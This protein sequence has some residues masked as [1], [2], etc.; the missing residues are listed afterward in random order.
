MTRL[1]PDINARRNIGARINGAVTSI[2]N[3]FMLF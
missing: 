2:G 3:V 1:A